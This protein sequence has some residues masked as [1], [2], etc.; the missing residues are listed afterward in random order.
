MLEDRRWY[1]Y[2]TRALCRKLDMPRE[3]LLALARHME[4]ETRRQINVFEYNG[5]EHMGLE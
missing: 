1:S 2:G 5:V 4:G 3:H